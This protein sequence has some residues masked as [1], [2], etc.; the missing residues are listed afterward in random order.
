MLIMGEFKLI[1]NFGG[2]I[3]DS[4]PSTGNGSFTLLGNPILTVAASPVGTNKT[5]MQLNHARPTG[6]F[7]PLMRGISLGV[8]SGGFDN[9]IT[10]TVAPTL[11]GNPTRTGPETPIV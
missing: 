5:N 6:G 9:E 1:G 11:V 10:K 2:P 7:T 4:F 3:N 8:P